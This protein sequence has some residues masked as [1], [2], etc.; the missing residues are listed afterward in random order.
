LRDPV[1]HVSDHVE[2]GFQRQKVARRL[3]GGFAQIASHADLLVAAADMI[4]QVVRIG[5]LAGEIYD[6][7]TETVRVV[8]GQDRLE[9]FQDELADELL[10]ISIHLLFERLRIGDRLADAPQIGQDRPQRADEG[11]RFHPCLAQR[12]RRLSARRLGALFTQTLDELE[13]RLDMDDKAAETLRD[14][15]AQRFQALDDVLW[16]E[17]HVDRDPQAPFILFEPSRTHEALI[18][19]R[20]KSEGTVACFVPFAGKANSAAP[21]RNDL[22][23]AFR[24]VVFVSDQFGVLSELL[25]DDADHVPGSRIRSAAGEELPIAREQGRLIGEPMLS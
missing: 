4:T 13:A 5:D 24:R 17:R 12:V 3:L 22:G 1:E 10:E 9:I 19:T 21:S 8:I 18:E 14:V 11:I 6:L 20:C 16:P 2:G 15:G 25:V 7:V 23:K